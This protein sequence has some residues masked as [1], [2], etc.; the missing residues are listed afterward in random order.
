MPYRRWLACYGNV[1]RGMPAA[2]A[3]AIC[4]RM[5]ALRADL[6]LSRAA[7]LSGL[8]EG[9]QNLYLRL[10]QFGE[11]LSDDVAES[12][13]GLARLQDRAAA[14]LLSEVVDPAPITPFALND[15]FQRAPNGQLSF[16]CVVDSIDADLGLRAPPADGADAACDDAPRTRTTLDPTRFAALDGALVLARLALLDQAG[17]RQLTARFGGD[18]AEPRMGTQRRYSVLLDAM[19]SLDGS[20]PW[21]G[22]SMPFPR[23]APYR[24]AGPPVSAGY[25]FGGAAG[26]FG[27]PLYQSEALRRTA[28]T[29]L[30]P[31]PFEGAI[32]SRAEMQPGNYPFRPCAGD[33][34][35]PAPAGTREIC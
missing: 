2:S 28:F 8:G 18:P 17:V 30:F 11:R 31:R 10:V 25:A 1:L 33:P 32:L 34:L 16:R 5:R 22:T 12:L 15:A 26:P 27:F 7:L 20:Q 24:E 14:D 9:P 19:R 4:Q 6:S 13:I 21:R 35:R 3:E 29:A 23:R